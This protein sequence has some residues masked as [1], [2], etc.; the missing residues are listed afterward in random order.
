MHAVVLDPE[1]QISEPEHQPGCADGRDEAGERRR[2]DDGGAAVFSPVVDDSGSFL[3][4]KRLRLHDVLKLLH[5]FTGVVHM[6]SQVAV[7]EAEHVSIEG[8]TDGHPAFVPLMDQ[9]E[10][11]QSDIKDI[12][13]LL[14]GNLQ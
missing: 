13:T 7:K 4:I 2:L 14:G 3:T 8:Q 9:R 10:E 1:V 5:P 11:R 12:K 6:S